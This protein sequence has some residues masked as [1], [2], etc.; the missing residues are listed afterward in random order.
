MGVAKAISWDYK[1]NEMI[2]HGIFMVV[3]V[4]VSCN[5]NTMT[6]LSWHI[7]LTALEFHTYFMGISFQNDLVVFLE[8]GGLLLVAGRLSNS[9]LSQSQMHPPILSG[10]DHLTKLLFSSLHQSLVIV[11]PLSSFPIHVPWSMSSVPDV[12]LGLPAGAA[13][14]AAGSLTG[15]KP[16]R[17]DSCQPTESLPVLRS[18]SLEWTLWAL[19]GVTLESLRLL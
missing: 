5:E 2:I 12:L 16:S 8:D 4:Y 6:Q 7:S 9:N 14:P 3:V 1:T 13:L 17:W 11:A 19:L 15:Q 18:L 10:T